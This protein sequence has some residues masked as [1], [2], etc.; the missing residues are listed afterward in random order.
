MIKI[1]KYLNLKFLYLNLL[2]FILAGCSANNSQDG[3]NNNDTILDQNPTLSHPSIQLAYQFSWDIDLFPKT[4]I[5]VYTSALQSAHFNK[6][7][8]KEQGRKDLKIYKHLKSC[9]IH[10]PY[11]QTL[12]KIIDKQ[13]TQLLYNFSTYLSPTDKFVHFI[14]D[15][16]ENCYLISSNTEEEQIINTIQKINLDGRVQY[17]HRRIVEDRLAWKNGIQTFYIQLVHF[18]RST[19]VLGRNTNGSL[20]YRIEKRSGQLDL[21]YELKDD[22]HS[23]QTTDNG[24]LLVNSDS[25]IF[26]I[27]TL[28]NLISENKDLLKGYTNVIAVDNK[29]ALYAYYDDLVKIQKESGAHKTLPMLHIVP[30]GKDSY[31]QIQTGLPTLNKTD[32]RVKITIYKNDINTPITLSFLPKAIPYYNTLRLINVENNKIYLTAGKRLNNKIYVFDLKSHTLIDQQTYQPLASKNHYTSQQNR[33]SW[34][35]APE[36]T[37]FIPVQGIS[38]FYIFIVKF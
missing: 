17:K 8:L 26:E 6:H 9:Y 18:G 28:G 24:F 3:I 34:G 22:I 35:I 13:E 20:L 30:S 21:I 32:N 27:D 4:I 25:K 31:Y 37:V 5:P 10:D 2:T 38:A 16:N 36:G 19:Y 12:Y 1:I 33:Y 14:L 7:E 11:L 29:N 15:E 23:I